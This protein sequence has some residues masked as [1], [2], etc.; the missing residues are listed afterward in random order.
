MVCSS[1][2][3]SKPGTFTFWLLTYHANPASGAVQGE[4]YVHE[5]DG[6]E[7]HTGFNAWCSLQ[8]CPAPPC[9]QLDPMYP[10][11]S[12]VATVEQ[13]S[14]EMKKAGHCT[15]VT[16]SNG[17]SL[18]E[19]DSILQCYEPNVG[20]DPLK[21]GSAVNSGQGTNP[22]GDNVRQT[23]NCNDQ[24]DA[25]ESPTAS[26]RPMRTAYGVLVEGVKAGT[27]KTW[28]VGT[29]MNLDPSGK[30]MQ[31][32]PCGMSQANPY[33]FD[34]S[35][36]DGGKSCVDPPPVM[37]DALTSSLTY[38][39]PG[40]SRVIFSGFVCSVMCKAGTT[41][42]GTL[43]CKDGVW[44]A[45]KC[46]S[47]KTCSLP[48]EGGNNMSIP[49]RNDTPSAQWVAG[50]WDGT[51][52]P[53]NSPGCG[54]ITEAGT[55]CNYTCNLDDS[56]Y[57][58]PT[59]TTPTGSI[60]LTGVPLRSSIVCGDDGNWYPSDGFCGCRRTP[61]DT[62]TP[63]FTQTLTQSLTPTETVSLTET[64]TIT[65]TATFT[66]T[67]TM[68]QRPLCLV[69]GP[70]GSVFCDEQDVLPWWPW[71]L[72]L[73]LLC[74]CCCALFAWLRSRP[75]PDDP[76]EEEMLQEDAVVEEEEIEVGVKAVPA[77]PPPPLP[78]PEEEMYAMPPSVQVGVHALPTTDI[79]IGVHAVPTTDIDIGVHAVS[80]SNDIDVTVQRAGDIQVSV[81]NAAGRDDSVV[82]RR[83][84]PHNS[85]L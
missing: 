11:I 80:S 48:G 73:L 31:G 20:M 23:I 45:Y 62:P 17:T 12:G 39:Q 5:P 51:P 22:P 35:V 70:M 21:F 24:I 61:C 18:M 75:P 50:V 1:T 4:I 26:D 19:P 67:P 7:P 30:S 64:L 53:P 77:P 78:E 10:G 38:C 3:P 81:R 40:P 52:G 34:I 42:V 41:R 84:A 47:L 63:T 74:L 25:G 28:T 82:K 55:V 54:T 58:A 56:P 65:P 85:I 76:E 68:T 57:C 44:S 37:T 46:T 6:R 16:N 43:E 49:G 33:F 79:D 32:T 13:I 2:S 36:A 69:L 9:A 72:M 60:K 14:S 66:L 83:N 27:Y 29:D 15:T 59:R 71:L 8:D